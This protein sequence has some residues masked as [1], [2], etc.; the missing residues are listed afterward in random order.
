MQDKEIKKIVDVKIISEEW[1]RLPKSGGKGFYYRC[2]GEVKNTGFSEIKELVIIGAIY[3]KEEKQLLSFVD[4][5]F[6][7]I[8][9]AGYF[10]LFNLKPDDTA[11]YTIVVNL[12]SS[13]ELL[14]GKRRLKGIE[15]G[16]KDEKLKHKAFLVYDKKR[17]DD[18]TKKWFRHE[19]VK[20]VKLLKSNW[21]IKE[22]KSENTIVFH[23]TGAVGNTGTVDIENLEITASII[24]KESGAPLKWVFRKRK[25]KGEFFAE[26]N[27]EE[28]EEDKDQEYRAMGVIQIPFLKIN[29]SK[30][31]DVSF[32]LPSRD[33]IKASEWNHE[34][35]LK[36]LE[37]KRLDYDI[38]IYT[39]EEKLDVFAYRDVFEDPTLIQDIKGTRKVEILIE[40]WILERDKDRSQFRCNCTVK[41]TGNLDLESVYVI[42]SIYDVKKNE[43]LTWESG[44]EI[45]KTLD[46][47]KIKYLKVNEQKTIDVLVPL[48]KSKVSLQDGYTGENIT[49]KIDTGELARK[50]DLYYRKEEVNEEAIKRLNL[51]NA[52]FRL[53]N[54]SACVK[55]YTEG[56]KLL[57]Q[58]R[59]FYFNLGLTY[60][61]MF[62]FDE[63]HDELQQALKIDSR[64]EK[65]L[66][67]QG[68]VHFKLKE[69]D[70]AIDRLRRVLITDKNNHKIYYNISCAFFEKGDRN[71]GYSWLK[72]AL[73]INK[74]QV[75]SKALRDPIFNSYRKDKHFMEILQGDE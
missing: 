55:E 24:D 7:T 71:N 75:M 43:P 10:A 66:Y 74:T 36:G 21:D 48:P 22:I 19:G 6:R 26:L 18:K 51:G 34:S 2:E 33:V 4:K 8:K 73:S 12:P 69:W 14:L 72:K 62:R 41:N 68:L 39:E 50:T 46:I 20:R 27:I 16:I 9:S 52:Y 29:E 49:E 11:N 54:F 25:P 1:R 44:N 23:C 15:K 64:S 61:K 45:F 65:T 70:M 37:D 3:K 40:D 63:A 67:L 5:R 53:G 42:S 17:L 58:E 59:R 56:K 32:R 57:P 30:D 35:I 31:F 60:Y 38:D 13:S 47:Q 28:E